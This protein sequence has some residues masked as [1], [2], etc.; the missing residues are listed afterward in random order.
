VYPDENHSLKVP[1]YLVHRMSSNIDWFD[2]WLRA[3]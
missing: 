1:S 2:R 3:P